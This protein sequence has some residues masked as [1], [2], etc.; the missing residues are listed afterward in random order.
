MIASAKTP[1]ASLVPGTAYRLAA[2][3]GPC[4]PDESKGQLHNAPLATL[5]LNDAERAGG[6]YAGTRAVPDRMVEEVKRLSTKLGS[7]R[8][9]DGELLKQREIHV[10]IP[11][12]TQVRRGPG[13]GAPGEVPGLG[14]YR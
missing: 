3:A 9:A 8:F 11:G 7:Q 1:A 10:I 14:K 4:L 6:V 2:P 12:T 5:V 13:H